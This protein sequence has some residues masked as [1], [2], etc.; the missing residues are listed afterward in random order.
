MDNPLIA[1]ASTSIEAPASRVWD[2][3]VTPET[4]KRYM[5]GATVV[6]DWKEGRPI[7]WKGE[8]QGKAY[9][10]KGVILELQPGRRLRFS[11]FSPLS[12]LADTPENHHTVTIDLAEE[13]GRTLV[14]LTQDNNPSEEARA[15]SEENWRTVLEGLKQLL[16]E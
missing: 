1:Q 2:A 10:D 14:T 7:V 11:H 9:E 12:G 4:I 8:L 13:G 15:H 3:L 5:F 6:S 16:E